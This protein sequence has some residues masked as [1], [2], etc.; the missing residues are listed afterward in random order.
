MGQVD[1]VEIERNEQIWD[2]LGRKKSVKP[3]N[4]LNKEGKGEEKTK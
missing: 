4:G 3:A 2:T 1:T